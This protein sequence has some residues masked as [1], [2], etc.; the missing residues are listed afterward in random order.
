MFA[1]LEGVLSHKSPSLLYMDIGGVGYELHISLQTYDKVQHLERC[2]LF[3][4]L[5]IREDAWVL[6]GFADEVERTTFR[7]LL[8][9]TGV[10][11][12]TAR[13]ILSYLTPVELG[14]AVSSGDNVTLQRVKG[15]GAKTA[16]RIVLEL[17]GKLLP[18]DESFT[19]SGTIPHNTKEQDALIA[20]MNLGIAKPAAT[21]ALK[22]A[23]ASAA[24][25][26]VEDLIKAA[27]RS[28]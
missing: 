24:D 10:G 26:S 2:R 15:I 7:A 9:I 19:A 14:R 3:T 21:E 12:A 16:Q 1:Y 25:A 13:L 23:G 8:A 6:Y 11:A 22:K 27:L 5:Q 18:V 20:L 17:K 28:L 4:H